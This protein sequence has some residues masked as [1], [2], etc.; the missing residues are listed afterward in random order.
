M[1]YWFVLLAIVLAACAANKKIVLDPQLTNE[2]RLRF[3]Q[4]DTR[5]YIQRLPELYFFPLDKEVFSPAPSKVLDAALSGVLDPEMEAKSVKLKKFNVYFSWSKSAADADARRASLVI[6][7]AII[8]Y[9]HNDRVTDRELVGCEFQARYRGRI[10][11]FYVSTPACPND[12]N[13]CI[14]RGFNRKQMPNFDGYV[15]G[16]VRELTNQ[17]IANAVAL[18]KESKSLPVL[19][20]AD[21]DAL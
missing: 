5:Y 20:Q 7:E 21:Q 13:Q 4:D 2:A 14:D 12:A 17:C 6:G 8:E 3:I 1:R 16:K 18:I 19:E 15:E 9:A 10:I 11:E